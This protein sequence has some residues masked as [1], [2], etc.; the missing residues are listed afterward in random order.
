ME[1][2][3]AAYRRRAEMRPDDAEAQYAVGVY[4]WQQLYRLGGG[5]DKASFDPRPDPNAA[6]A[7]AKAAKL[8]KKRAK[9]HKKGVEPPPPAKQLPV[10]DVNDIV[11]SRRIALVELG[12]VYLERALALR[13]N[14][15]EAM[16]YVN[17][18]WRQKS[19]AY[20]SAP[21]EWQACIDEAEKWRAKAEAEYAKGGSA[22][23]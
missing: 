16:A 3:L 7:A 2:A 4:I 11:D 6:L 12:I 5:P 18:L 10:F 19:I 13:P 21:A 17:L 14:Y 9:K 22:S 23:R 15:R 20:F 8:Q 1:E